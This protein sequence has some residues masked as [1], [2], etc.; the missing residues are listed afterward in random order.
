MDQASRV[1][2]VKS[3][4]SELMSERS[5]Y[6]SVG[7]KRDARQEGASVVECEQV[8]SAGCGVVV[9]GSREERTRR[10]IMLVEQ[11]IHHSKDLH[12]LR[13]L[14]GRMHVGEPIGWHL[15]IEVGV[16]VN[17][18]LAA[19]HIEIGAALPVAYSLP[20]LK[21]LAGIPGI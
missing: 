6:S 4:G 14:V 10:I 3:R 21:R 8:G 15:W 2:D 18:I 16:I 9:A 5:L 20:I 19:E 17:Q 1:P 12:V 13:H 11:V 7:S